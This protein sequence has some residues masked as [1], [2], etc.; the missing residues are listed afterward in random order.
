MIEFQAFMLV[1]AAPVPIHRKGFE[2]P[3]L[4]VENRDAL[5]QLSYAPIPASFLSA[6]LDFNFLSRRSSA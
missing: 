3:T 6:G 4:P 5:N 2:P 1:G